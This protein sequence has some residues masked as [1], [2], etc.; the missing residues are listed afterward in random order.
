MGCVQVGVDARARARARVC[1]RVCVCACGCH[2]W[3][4]VANM[5]QL[6][7]THVCMRAVPCCVIM[8]QQCVRA[9]LVVVW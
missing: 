4:R 5:K 6:G 2:G 7:M 8:E 9:Q 1:V 3:A